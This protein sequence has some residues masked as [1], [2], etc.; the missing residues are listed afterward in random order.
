ML[1]LHSVSHDLSKYW[2]ELEGV[3]TTSSCYDKTLPVWSCPIKK[4]PA[5]VSQ[6]IQ[7]L[8]YAMGASESAGIALLK[9]LRVRAS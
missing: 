8:R 9:N 1:M 3:P 6:Y 4:L 7:I 5:K 2:R